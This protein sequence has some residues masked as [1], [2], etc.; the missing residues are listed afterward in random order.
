MATIYTDRQITLDS[1]KNGN[2][3]TFLI[4]EIRRKLT[5]M[6]KQTGKFSFAG[7]KFTSGSKEMS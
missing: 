2:I 5:E 1:L 6:G 3:H 4:E 7:V